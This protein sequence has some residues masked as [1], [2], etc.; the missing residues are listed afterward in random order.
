VPV[1]GGEGIGEL[2][3]IQRQEFPDFNWRGSV[4]GGVHLLLVGVAAEVN[5]YE[6]YDFLGG[7]VGYDPSGDDVPVDSAAWDE[8]S[9]DNDES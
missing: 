9:E 6:I 8:E 2:L 4:G 1:H 3:F 5:P 7:L